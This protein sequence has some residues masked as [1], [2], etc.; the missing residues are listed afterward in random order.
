MSD[1]NT[2]IKMERDRRKYRSHEDYF[3]YLSRFSRCIDSFLT[4]KRADTAFNRLKAKKEPI[5]EHY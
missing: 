3:I 1:L 2:P 4:N 5:K